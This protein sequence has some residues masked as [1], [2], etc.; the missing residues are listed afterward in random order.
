ML[1]SCTGD[2]REP[3]L[4][5]AETG[6]QRVFA[7]RNASVESLEQVARRSWGGS[8]PGGVQGRVGSGSEQLDLVESGP[9]HG[10]GFGIR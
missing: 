6:T 5:F 3:R 7:T 1:G 9:A 8:K 10:R 2:S 4:P